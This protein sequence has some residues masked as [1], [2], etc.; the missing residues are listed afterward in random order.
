MPELLS[1]T[2]NV[3]WFEAGERA[4]SKPHRAFMHVL[5]AGHGNVLLPIANHPVQNVV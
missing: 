4:A 2:K 1:Q 3:P 5:E